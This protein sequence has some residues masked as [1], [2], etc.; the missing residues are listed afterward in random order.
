MCQCAAAGDVT[1]EVASFVYAIDSGACP[2]ASATGVVAGARALTPD[3]MAFEIELE[4]PVDFDAGQFMAVTMPGIPGSAAA[5]WSTSTARAQARLRRKKKPAAA[6]GWLF[7]ADRQALAVE[8]FGPL[9][10]ATFHPSLGKHLLCIAGGSGIA[11]MMAI[12]ARACQER[13]F[14]HFRGDVFFGVRTMV[15]AF[16]LQELAAFRREFQ[17]QLAITVALSDERRPRARG[18]R[19]PPAPLRARLG[20]RGGEEGDAGTVPERPGVSRRAATSGGRRNPVPAA[21]S[22]A[23]RGQHQVRQVQ[24]KRKPM[25][26]AALFLTLGSTRGCGPSYRDD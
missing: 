4:R 24:L 11:G 18:A 21:G 6:V 9:G 5:R 19:P 7:G 2:A 13:Y 17:D 16:Y 20:A 1:A 15:D 12:L 23:D 8:L 26:K 14:T 3:V 10:K 22:E 25:P